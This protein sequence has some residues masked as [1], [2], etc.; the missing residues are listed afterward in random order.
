MTKLVNLS[1]SQDHR[2]RWIVKIFF[3]H[4]E[5]NDNEISRNEGHPTT[6][7]KVNI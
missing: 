6:S 2:Q 3:K 7:S 5:S 1:G 4:G